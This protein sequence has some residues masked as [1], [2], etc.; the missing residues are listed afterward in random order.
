MIRSSVVLPQ[1]DGPT[2][3]PTSPLPS[4]NARRP[5]TLSLPPLEAANDLCRMSTS[6]RFTPGWIVSG[7]FGAPAGDMSFKRLHQQGFDHQ[8]HGGEGEGVGEDL[9]D[10]E[11]LERRADL[12]A[13]AIGT[14]EQFDDQHD[15]PH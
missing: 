7:G 12:E 14:P 13:D 5:I 1:P 8:H 10:V 11:Q 4:E 15:L 6:S 3:A 2:S 9:G